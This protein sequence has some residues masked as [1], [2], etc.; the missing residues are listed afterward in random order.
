MSSR[1]IEL[2]N[3]IAATV[4]I[5]KISDNIPETGW[6]LRK[7]WFL[8]FDYEELFG[9]NGTIGIVWICIRPPEIVNAI[10]TSAEHT[11]VVERYAV[12]MMVC[13]PETDSQDETI[14]THVHL[15]QELTDI[16]RKT[17]PLNGYDFVRAEPVK[18]PNGVPFNYIN[19]ERGNFL[20]II[21]IEFAKPCK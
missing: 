3:L 15:V 1:I 18:D 12:H 10:R 7:E 21:Q 8:N 4:E 11:G 2:R 20:T 17:V 14:S 6:E 19:M 13:F 9:E 5:A 16:I